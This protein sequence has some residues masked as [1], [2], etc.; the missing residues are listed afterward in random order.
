[1]SGHDRQWMLNRRNF[2]GRWCGT[3]HWYLRGSP[4]DLGAGTELDLHAPRVEIPDTCYTISFQ[5][6]DTGLWDGR[7]LLLAPG[8][9]RQLPLARDTYNSA[10]S[11][12]QFPGVGGQ[13]SL[14]VGP[15]QTRFGHEVNLFEGR[16]RSMLVLLYGL[17]GAD[18]G[19][20]WRLD[21]VAA[22][23][24]RCH[25]RPGPVDPPRPSATDWTSLLE[26]QEGWPGTLERLVP[27]R[28]PEQDSEPIA[29]RPFSRSAFACNVLTAGFV[30]G[31]V[32]SVPEVLGS[33]AFSLQVGCR[34]APHRFHQVSL[35]FDER[36]RLSAWELRR[37]HR[38]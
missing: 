25:Q 7:G 11:C 3:S 13:S 34:L 18:D 8:G 20:R 35:L 19:S 21:A 17:H 1:M 30:D 31:L 37:F 14:A 33:G 4:T 6:D 28:W 26:E 24:F 5:D 36:Q 2:E 9:S 12:W 23:P 22:V 15:N 29:C 32:F 10:G 38:P 16:S 27:H